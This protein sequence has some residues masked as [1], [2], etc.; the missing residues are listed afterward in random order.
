[1]LSKPTAI[2]RITRI[3]IMAS[4][5]EFVQFDNSQKFVEK[6]L[7][8]CRQGWE[9]FKDISEYVYIYFAVGLFIG[10][11]QAFK[12]VKG[13]VEIIIPGAEV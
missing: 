6:F 8:G 1:M 12:F 3:G 9:L 5:K 10:I 13:M 4:F 2:N 7:T 11:F